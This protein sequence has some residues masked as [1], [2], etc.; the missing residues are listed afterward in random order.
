MEGWRD[1]GMDGV[2]TIAF[3]AGLKIVR[4]KPVGLDTVFKARL[5]HAVASNLTDVTCIQVPHLCCNA[6]LFHQ[7]LLVIMMRARH[8]RTK[9]E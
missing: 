9:D 6:V 3:R 1:G 5:V 7:G 2:Y 8:S 4:T